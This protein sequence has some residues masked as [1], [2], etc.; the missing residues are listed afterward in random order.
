MLIA[1]AAVDK[2]L[3][4]GYNGEL[5]FHIP[6]DMKFFKRVTTGNIVIMGRKT[7]ESLH[8]K[9]LP[10]RVN[11][12]VSSDESLKKR[13][14][15]MALSI[16]EAHKFVEANKNSHTIY[17]IG[18]AKIY[19]EFIDECNLIFLTHYYKAFEKA[20]AYFPDP[21]EH[22]FK[23]ECTLKTGIWNDYTWKII[24]WTKDSNH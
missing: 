19:N 13:K 12:V 20:D 16:D 7:F 22:N 2:D 24:S 4:I 10:N 18:G 5:L 15:I 8:S 17:I 6:D 9:P 23:R 14:D 3:A 21:K 11:I 1:I